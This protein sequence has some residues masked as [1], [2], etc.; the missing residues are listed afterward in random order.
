MELLDT[1][2]KK[3][4]H[5]KSSP[6]ETS[7]KTNA[8]DNDPHRSRHGGIVFIELDP[9]SAADSHKTRIGPGI[10]QRRGMLNSIRYGIRES[11]IIRFESIACVSWR[12]DLWIETVETVGSGGR[13][14]PP[15]YT[16]SAG[17]GNQLFRHGRH[18]FSG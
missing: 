7:V 18:V 9:H 16:E 15:V 5:A 1:A 10:L 13:R 17:A 11:G 12:H 2:S 14:S 8:A 3:R 6:V 4:T